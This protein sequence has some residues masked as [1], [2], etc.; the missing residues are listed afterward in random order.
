MS[1]PRTPRRARLVAA[2]VL[3]LVATPVA[4]AQD[5]DVHA[6]LF[7]D[8]L[9]SLDGGDAPSRFTDATLWPA[10]SLDGP[11]EVFLAH[12]PGDDGRWERRVQVA[13]RVPSVDGVSGRVQLAGTTNPLD[14]EESPGRSVPFVLESDDFTATAD[15]VRRVERDHF[16][17]MLR[18]QLPGGAWFRHRRDVAAAQVTAGEAE[19][20]E[21]GDPRGTTSVEDSY[22]LLSGGRAV[23]ENLALDR[24]LPP[25][26][27]DE[28]TVSIHSVIG[29]TVPAYDWTAE[30][31]A[32]T[33]ERVE[34]GLPAAPEHDPLARL[35]PSD[36]HAV[37]FPSFDALVATADH[38]EEHGAP[39]LAALE[40][41][42]E[43][44][45]TRDRYEAQLGVPMSALSRLLG[46]H[47]VRSVAITGA[48]PY[49][50]TGADVA[51]LLEGDAAVLEPLLKARVVLAAASHEGVSAGE[52]D[53]LGVPVASW[54]TP[55]RALSSHVAR[56][57]DDAV[58]VTN[59]LA[60][61]E[62]LVETL[63]GERTALGALDEY[64]W[65]RAR[66][67]RGDADETA[68][69]VLSDETIR[70]WCGP[71][72]RIGSSRRSRAAAV[73]AEWQTRLAARVVDDATDGEPLDLE[74]LDPTR[75][76]HDLGPLVL[77]ARGV[78]SETWGDLRFATPIL[79]L[80]LDRVTEAEADLYGRWRRGYESNWVELFDPIAIRLTVDER[81]LAM[82]MTV[83]PLVV[84]SDYRQLVDSATGATIS[85]TAGDP[86]EGA[87]L[88]WIT[89]FN[90][91]AT[92][93]TRN[94]MLGMARI[95]V[96]SADPLG[97]IGESYAFYVDADPLWAELAVAE[98]LDDRLFHELHRLP[99]A[100]HAEVGDPLQLT[101]F[102]A[103]ARAI[104]EQSAP[105]MLAWEN[106]E[107]A[108]RAYVRLEPTELALEEM[109]DLMLGG[110]PWTPPAL[111]YA[112]SG[113]GLVVS[114]SEDLVKRALERQAWRVARKAA[115]GGDDADPAAELPALTPGYGPIT[116]P[117]SGDQLSVRVSRDVVE[118][119][120][121]GLVANDVQPLRELAWRNLPILDAW[122]RRWPDR[123]PLA[124]HE[125][126]WGRRL[127][128]PA[129]GSYVWNEEDGRMESTLYGHPGRPKRGPVLP[130][131]VT[132][133]GSADF[134]LDFEEDGLRG[135]VTLVRE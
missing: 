19:V 7:L 29:V 81:R 66:Y 101:L 131:Q 22:R 2:L 32:V 118:L 60:Q 52:G 130:S 10:V 69:V 4:R 68:F 127:L 54:T 84:Q 116:T 70:R 123:D 18:A 49:L 11:G 76:L 48:D 124:V 119:V 86:H 62:R 43:T 74:L 106:R 42:T 105:G 115:A 23:S 82:D 93:V 102:L 78:R 112:A 25:A 75:E 67:A 85:P 28:D 36:Q 44:A 47:V 13:F 15:D 72:W 98:G 95:M 97:W 91:H 30:L 122:K 20:F 120:E 61:L 135:R 63:L 55:D 134:G 94:E 103:G 132:G 39:V 125:V 50:R 87:L 90:R 64:A 80:D 71:R 113:Q 56:L 21:R 45:G 107:H 57:G 12:E 129:G 92:S 9:V 110:E 6:V 41:R 24:M 88:H 99:V 53:V 40:P 79:E 17:R 109:D 5:A 126:L 128:C 121:S 8:E 37:F 59:S 77:G 51:L 117:W 31:E 73:L 27:D 100:L 104:I 83:R 3:S 16:D 108:G 114:F 96:P 46:P 35:V 65:F 58:V 133:I 14:G 89:A 34:A 38:A 1:V 111:H 26:P 33:A